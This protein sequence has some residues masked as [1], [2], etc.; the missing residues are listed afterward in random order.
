[1]IRIFVIALGCLFLVAPVFAEEIVLNSG[2]TVQGTIIERTDKQIKMNASGVDVTYYMDEIRSI[3]GIPIG[4]PIK[5][6]TQPKEP[7]SLLK[8][9]NDLYPPKNVG[10][11]AVVEPTSEMVPPVEHAAL[12]ADEPPVQMQQVNNPPVVFNA[13][14][15]RSIKSSSKMTFV[16]AIGIIMITLIVLGLF[17]VTVCY[18]LFLI[19]QKTNAPYPFFA[20]IPILN[21]YLLCKISGRPVWWMVL[22]VIPLVSMVIDVLVWMDIAKIRRKPAW[23]GALIIVPVVNLGMMWYLAM[24]DQPSV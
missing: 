13:S 18:P 14:S 17:I 2:S 19:A 11:A 16:Q 15:S 3:D 22:Y 9:K 5:A 23:M 24:S 10:T 7:S 8:S 20:F 12:V 4:I 21:Y 1:M 6:P